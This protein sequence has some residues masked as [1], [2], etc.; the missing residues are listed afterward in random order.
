M[1]KI[2]K[3][4]KQLNYQIEQVE[5]NIKYFEEK[6]DTYDCIIND[7]KKM[8]IDLKNKKGSYLTPLFVIF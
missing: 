3:D 6:R 8:L 2:K 7:Y 1:K 5:K 4:D